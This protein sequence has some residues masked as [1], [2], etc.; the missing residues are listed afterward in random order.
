MRAI[1]FDQPGGAEVLYCAD[2]PMP[3]PAAHEVLIKVAAAGVNRP[4]ILQRCGLYPPPPNACP[5][6]GLEVSGI[7]EAVGNKVSRWKKGDAVCALT[8]GGGYADY[9]LADAGCLMPVPRGMALRDAAALPETVLTVWQNVFAKAQLKP[10]ETLLV[11]GASSGIGTTAI[12]MAKA[13]GAKVLA[14][15]RTDEKCALAM[16]LGT[17]LAIN[18]IENDFAVAVRDFGGA[19]VVLD[20][21]CGSFMAGNLASLNPGGRLAIIAFLG[22]H[23]IEA[24]MVPV[25]QKHLHI[26]G[27]TLRPLPLEQKAGLCR[28]VES[29]VWPWVEANKVQPLIEGVFAL[30]QVAKAHRQMES[31]AHKGKLLLIP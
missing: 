14:T 7:V 4:D 24:S 22:G 11:H 26:F 16:K 12:Q 28:A 31:A 2:I 23:K 3:V 29:E 25:L 17:D 13:H 6:L 10:G 9:A 20:M 19:D 27:T 15:A 5:R 8:P 1:Q 30:E 18:S 21:V